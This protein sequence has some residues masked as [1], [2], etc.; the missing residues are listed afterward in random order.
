[1]VTSCGN[2]AWPLEIEVLHMGV[3]QHQG[4]HFGVP[5]MGVIIYWCLHKG[6]PLP[7]QTAICRTWVLVPPYHSTASIKP[8]YYSTVDKAPICD[9]HG[10]G[11]GR[12]RRQAVSNAS[13]HS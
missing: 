12:L 7:L 9:S 6:S 11:L 3:V 13:P 5:V 2:A 4:F 1:M 10:I 8:W